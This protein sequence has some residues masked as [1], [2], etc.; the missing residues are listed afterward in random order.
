MRVGFSKKK[1]KIWFDPSVEKPEHMKPSLLELTMHNQV[2]AKR[3]WV[4]CAEQHTF[5]RCV[6]YMCLCVRLWNSSCVCT[7]ILNVRIYS[8]LYIHKYITYIHTYCMCVR[9]VLYTYVLYVCTYSTLYVH[10]EHRYGLLLDLRCAPLIGS[11]N[12]LLSC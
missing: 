9:T 8:T 1:F 5:F 11:H 10:T 6:P 3:L 2:A 4:I 7:H 12:M